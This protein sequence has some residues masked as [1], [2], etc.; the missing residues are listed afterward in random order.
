[1][2]ER[3]CKTKTNVVASI[4]MSDWTALD[5]LVYIIIPMLLGYLM[6]RAARD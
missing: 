4:P 6:G 3:V 1:M 5:A 2:H